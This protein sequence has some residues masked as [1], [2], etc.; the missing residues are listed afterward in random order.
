MLIRPQTKRA[1][2]HRE[3]VAK[4]AAGDE[5]VTNGGLLGRISEVG[6]H[7]VTLQVSSGVAIQVQKIQVAQLMPKGTFKGA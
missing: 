3:M 7:F 6:E 2:E 1:K 5:V 4:L